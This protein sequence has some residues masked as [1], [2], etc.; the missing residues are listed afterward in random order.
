LPHTESRRTAFFYITL[1]PLIW[2]TTFAVTKGALTDISPVLFAFIRFIL[3]IVIFFSLFTISR[4]A[5]MII[6]KP[7]TQQERDLRTDSIVLGSLLGFGYVLQFIGLQTSTTTD[8]AFI[9][10]TA[11][12]WTPLFAYFVI[13]EE[14]SKK[15]FV[16]LGI[17]TVGLVL[18]TQPYK[19]AGIVIGD[20]LTLISAVSFGLYIAWIDRALPR[21]A[22]YY[23][24]NRDAGLV[25]S[26]NQLLIATITIGLALLLIETPRIEVTKNLTYAVLYNGILATALTTYLQNRYQQTV[27]ATV[28]ALIFMLEPVVAAMVG[29]LFVGEQLTTEELFGAC[30][31]IVGVIVAQIRMPSRTKQ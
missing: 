6:V 11:A 1:I 30:L 5:A 15:T 27:S 29:F 3:T 19:M 9:T 21:T 23:G 18:L 4:Q 26:S 14:I 12:I 31:I 25:I 10:S 2:G 22:A 7:K 20:V 13:K 17:A 8:S 24:N 28:A 16:A